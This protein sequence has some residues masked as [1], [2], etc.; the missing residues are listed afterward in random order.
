MCELA[1][2]HC[3][4][5]HRDDDD[6]DDNDSN[7]WDRDFHN[8]VDLYKL[9]FVQYGRPHEFCVIMYRSVAGK[10]ILYAHRIQAVSVQGVI[11]R[12]RALPLSVKHIDI[13][14]K[15][16]DITVIIY[17][18]FIMPVFFHEYILIK[19][20]AIPVTGRGGPQGSE[21]LRFH[22]V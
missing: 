6:D 14:L 3:S 15:R 8:R 7:N 2:P 12:F 9:Y 5:K 4:Q 18:F 11:L 19:S 13:L 1:N 22:I 16:M 20:N 17:H 10:P 21:T